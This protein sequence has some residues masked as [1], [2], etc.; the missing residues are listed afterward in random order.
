MQVAKYRDFRFPAFP[1]FFFFSVE[2]ARSLARSS[3][4]DRET[5]LCPLYWTFHRGREPFDSSGKMKGNA[6]DERTTNARSLPESSL[7]ALP[8]T[9]NSRAFVANPRAIRRS[10]LITAT[11]NARARFHACEPRTSY[12]S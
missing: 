12:V 3:R 9:V 10:A 6:N 7:Y 11:T 4:V 1:S 8:S 2:Y 5:P